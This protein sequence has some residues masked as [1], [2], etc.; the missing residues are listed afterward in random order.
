MECLQDVVARLS[1][2]R[3][4]V[5]FIAVTIVHGTRSNKVTLESLETVFGRRRGT[6]KG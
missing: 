5:T 4:R 1:Q 2:S 6:L 3:F